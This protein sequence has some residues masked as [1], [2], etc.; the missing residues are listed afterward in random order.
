MDEIIWNESFSVGVQELDNQ[1]KKLIKILNKL[2]KMANA[3]VFSET[4]SDTLTE[5]TKYAAIHFETEEK[6]MKKFNYPDFDA[7]KEQHKAFQ[8]K[9]VG[10]CMY[11]MAYKSSVPTDILTFLMTWLVN[12]IL[13]SDMKYKD[14]FRDQEL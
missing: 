11:A 1:H 14:F 2:I 12:H 8:K 6:L 9:T 3:E 10:F 4:V 7:H 5:M 13:V